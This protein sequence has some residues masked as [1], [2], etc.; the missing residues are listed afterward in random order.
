MKKSFLVLLC[1]SLMLAALPALAETSTV[2]VAHGL[3][4]T[5]VPV[6]PARVVVFDY[7]ALDALNYAGI[8]VVGLGKGG[9]MPEHLAK[10]ADDAAYPA[11]GSLHEPNFEVVN[12]LKPDLILIGARAS[13]AYEELSKIAPTVLITMPTAGYLDTFE[14]NMA[15]LSQIFPDKADSFTGVVSDIRARAAAVAEK[16]KA[17]DSNALV[18][19]VSDGDM[20]VFGLGSRFAV[21]YD[22]FGFAVA[23]EAIEQSTHGQSATF[24]YVAEKNPDYL[25]VIDRSAATGAAEATGAMQVMDN[26]LINATA[27]AQNGHIVYLNSSNWYVAAGGIEATRTMVAE[28]EAAIAQ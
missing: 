15:I 28:L 17:T 2:T 19:M 20:S 11:A 12:E 22:D 3:G 1:L 21:V 23:D 8:D 13:T 10:Y 6:N 16:A 18:V 25:F 26:D 27:A 14:A 4:E 7:G 9:A 24:E 5:A